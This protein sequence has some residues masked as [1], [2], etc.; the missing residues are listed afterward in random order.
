MR[1]VGT[2]PSLNPTRISGRFG[3]TALSAF[4]AM[5]HQVKEGETQLSVLLTDRSAP[6][7]VLADIEAL[8]LELLEV[9]QIPVGSSLPATGRTSTRIIGGPVGDGV[10]HLSSRE[11]SIESGAKAPRAHAGVASVGPRPGNGGSKH[12]SCRPSRHRQGGRPATPS[13]AP[14]WQRADNDTVR[15]RDPEPARRAGQPKCGARAS[16][17]YRLPDLHGARP[18]DLGPPSVWMEGRRSGKSP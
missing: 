17:R 16:P 4:P 18:T 8:G 5:V 10:S 1:T 11:R 9:R 3:A 14:G 13:P 6:L 12:T 15:N 7:G 2:L